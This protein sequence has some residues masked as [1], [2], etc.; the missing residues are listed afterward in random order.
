MWMTEQQQTTP[1]T[2]RKPFWILLAICG[3]PYL[4]SWVWYANMDKLPEISANNRGELVEPVRPLENLMLETVDGQ[5]LETNFLKGNWV[6]MTAGTSECEEPCMQNIFFMRQVRRLMGEDREKIKRIFV[7]TDTQ[8]IDSFKEKVTQFGDMDIVSA[9]SGHG[10]KLIENM[11]LDKQTPENRIFIVDPLANLMMAYPQGVN[12]EDIAK[13]FRR[14]L[15]V[16][17]IGDPKEAG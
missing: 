6:L 9:I 12:P 11:T 10:K 15:K 1:K 17:R 5:I 14:L 2:N 3:L 4:L 7:M 16:V 8:Q 13:D